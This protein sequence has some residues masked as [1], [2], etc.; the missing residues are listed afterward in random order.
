MKAKD[1]VDH[2]TVTR[3]L[4]IFHSGCKNL[5]NQA[6]SGG[7]KTEDSKVMLM[8]RIQGV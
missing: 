1:I 4:K 3:C 6:K 7:P 8:N 5:D 2:S